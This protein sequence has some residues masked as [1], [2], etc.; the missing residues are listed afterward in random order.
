M[1]SEIG[2][3]HIEQFGAYNALAEMSLKANVP[4][5]VDEIQPLKESTIVFDFPGG[6]IPDLLN[7]FA[8]QAPDYEWRNEPNGMIRVSRRG[9]HVSLLDA[10]LAYPGRTR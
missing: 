7:Q 9:G 8:S 6:T 1:S 5:G 2:A 4:I 10:V 3:V